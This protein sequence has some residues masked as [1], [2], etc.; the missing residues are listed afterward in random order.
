M[1]IS[2]TMVRVAG[3]AAAVIAGAVAFSGGEASAA[4]A[5][6]GVM[7][8]TDI[9][10]GDFS[11]VPQNKIITMSFTQPVDAATVNPATVQIRAQ[12]AKGTGFTIQVAG[13]MQV[14][15]SMVR[16]LP[17]LPTHLHNPADP[18]GGYYPAGSLQ[19][20]AYAN[21]GLQPSKNHMITVIGL[22]S[23]SAIRSTSGRPLNKNYTARFT[24]AAASPKTEAF[25]TDTYQDDPPPQFSFSNP[26]DKVAVAVDQYARHGGTQDVPSAISVT[27]FGTKVPLSPSTIRQSGNVTLTM[28][29][30][31]DDP[32]FRKMVSGSPFIEQN[33]DTVR[34][35][36]V[37]RFALPDVASYAMA[38]SSKVL[39]LT[40]IYPFAPNSDRLRLRLMY[41]FLVTAR[42]LNP[43]TPWEQ[44]ANPPLDLISDLRDPWPTTDA[45]RGVLKRNLLTLGDT[46]RDEVDPRVMVLFTTRDEL[47]TV[48]SLVVNFLQSENYFDPSR[49]T[50]E[51]DQ[52]IPSAASAVFTVA[53]G[54]AVLGD[55]KPVTN[56]T[57]SIT[58]YPQGVFNFRAVVIPAG[59][60]VTF[61]GANQPTQPST[62]PANGIPTLPGST[63][64]ATLKCLSLQ[65]DGTI[66]VDGAIGIDGTQTG[67][68]SAIVTTGTPGVPG[69]PGGG[70]G[71]YAPA[72]YGQISNPSGTGGVGNDANLVPAS[73]VNGGRGGLGGTSS[74]NTGYTMA[75]GAGGGGGSRLAG[76]AGGNGTMSA[77]YQ[78]SY[79][80]WAG[81]GG[82]GGAGATGNADLATLVGGAG[83]GG[84]GNAQAYTTGTYYWGTP[85][86]SGGGGGGAL[87]VQTSATL[88]IGQTGLIRSRGGTGGK[89]VLTTY[90]GGGGGGGGGGGAVLLRSTKGFNLTNPA[91]AVDVSG[92]SGGQPTTSTYGT[93]GVGGTGG[94]G[95]IRY[96]DV[97]GGI[98]V[99]GGTQGT[100]TPVGAGV[101]SYVYSNFIDLG[102]DNAKIYDF[103]AADFIMTSGNDAILIEVQFAIE[104]PNKL[105]TALTTAINGQEN[106]TNIAQ[107]SQWLPVRVLDSTAGGA[108]AAQGITSN[109]AV[110]SIASKIAP[111]AY[112]FVRVRITFQLDST[113]TASSPLPFVDQMTLRYAFN[114]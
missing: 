47:V 36:F 94:A 96:E 78:A 51:W 67:V 92:G 55:L 12:N 5:S 13:S 104:N 30:R 18:S 27:V 85:G 19:D 98:S 109:D 57:Y 40:E 45:E 28:L 22:P 99:P 4:K 103:N 46:Y 70:Y 77:S 52:T 84:G 8:L 7:K 75:G 112:R 73:A 81:Y 102:V 60:T 24:T 71:G 42:M 32:S 89:G 82:A 54:S 105:G 16:F 1:R 86:A 59:V 63:P 21:A 93:G 69:G 3:G 49:S 113:Q 79:S 9:D 50:A 33:F 48:S 76:S 17:R 108:F 43:G 61:T 31:H 65:L 56:T 111:Y 20:D 62:P 29:A 6:K 91:A 38:V 107:V 100:Y 68:Y 110:F 35:S 11:G 44:L 26:P 95:F 2:R 74:P 39:D 53:G 106:S 23:I 72:Y 25:T 66:S 114:F 14:T 90:T 58:S 34:L 41:E 101:P 83:G 87:L 15:G 80:S 10:V 64:P 88:T 37:P 97:N